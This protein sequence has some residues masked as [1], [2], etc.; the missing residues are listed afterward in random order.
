MRNKYDKEFENFVR[1]NALKL[2][3]EELRKEI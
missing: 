1:D 2:K 3:K